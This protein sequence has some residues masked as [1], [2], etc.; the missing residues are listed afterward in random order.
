MSFFQSPSIRLAL[1]ASRWLWLVLILAGLTAVL[2]ASL[3][4]VVQ[5]IID[6]ALTQQTIAPHVMT[7]LTLAMS[8]PILQWLIS[9]IASHS[10]WSATNALRHAAATAIFAQPLEFFRNHGIGE[11]SERIDADSG[12]LHGVFGEA[13]A[14]LFSTIVLVFSVGVTTWL[15]DPFVFAVIMLYLCVG[16]A[17]IAWGQ[18]DNHHDWETERIA[19]AALYDTIEESF[20]SVTDMRAVGAEAHLHQ[21]L[22][23][24]IATLLHTHRT[25]RLRSQV[26]QLTSTAINAVGWLLA[27]GIG[28]WRY[29]NGTGSIGEAVALLGYVTLLT[30]PIE[31]IRG[32][33][34]E[35]QQ[36]RGVI[37]RIDELM[38]PAP[39]SD[40]TQTLPSGPLSVRLDQVSY[41]YPSSPD[42][43]IRGLSLDI[44]AGTHVA[45]IGRT[46]SGKTTLGRLVSH[47]EQAQQGT[48]LLNDI[49]IGDISESSLRSAVGV[50][51]QESDI[52]N[53]T[54]RDNITCFV[55]GYTDAAISAALHAC[56]LGDW[57]AALPDG[58]DTPIGD[59]ERALSPG[60]QQL[61]A[62]A[63]I[64]IRQPGIIVLDEASAHV[65]PA[66]EQRIATALA[67]LTNKRTTLTIAHR[68][69]TVYAA[70]LV[71]IMA[72]GVVIESGAPRQLATTPGSHFATLLA[73][74]LTEVL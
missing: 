3:P 57:L 72:D 41:R 23:P 32:I 61:L 12:Q 28:I 36:A 18:R 24:R 54:L 55:P 51:S 13:S 25:A 67:N 42:W 30:K 15:I 14:R 71:I 56:G 19:D 50:I 65:D 70:D 29:Q 9:S 64:A 49:P 35:Y 27:I 46:G 6:A 20:A 16:I 21:R 52:F 43:V 10:A 40:G 62:V 7:Y 48:I 39:I 4:F 5:H 1:T 60:E 53:A 44:P 11:L 59:G 26:A 34:Q 33:V 74:N 17:I 22:T 8:V 38:T 31:E 58:L 68:L 45:I 63:R 66:N 2:T 73:T 47:I 37:S 69:N